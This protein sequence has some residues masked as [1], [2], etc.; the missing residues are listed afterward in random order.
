MKSR[1]I[2]LM[3]SAGIIDTPWA[4]NPRLDSN[5]K[6]AHTNNRTIVRDGQNKARKHKR[7][8]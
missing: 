8:R 1:Q 7:R 3:Y 4:F 6:P 2:A 5:S